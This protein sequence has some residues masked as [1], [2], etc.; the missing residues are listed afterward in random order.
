MKVKII[1]FFLII[2]LL[3][4]IL[5]YSEDL[6]SANG[7]T[8]EVAIEYIPEVYVDSA[9][10]GD[11]IHNEFDYDAS[12]VEVRGIIESFEGDGSVNFNLETGEISIEEKVS[13]EAKPSNTVSEDGIKTEIPPYVP[14]LN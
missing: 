10:A 6:Q 1:S 4:T 13:Q 7:S 14:G 12:L 3:V 8:E 5:S 9:E 11:D 2:V